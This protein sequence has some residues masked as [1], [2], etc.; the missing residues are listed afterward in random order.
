MRLG[1]GGNDADERLPIFLRLHRLR[2]LVAPEGRRLLRV[3][4]LWNGSV[5]TNSTFGSRRVLLRLTDLHGVRLFFKTSPPGGHTQWPPRANSAYC[6]RT[7][8][9]SAATPWVWTST[10]IRSPTRRPRNSVGGLALNAMVIVGQPTAGIGPCWIVCL[11][12]LVSIAVMTPT[13]CPVL[14]AGALCPCP[15]TGHAFHISAHGLGVG[16]TGGQNGGG[17]QCDA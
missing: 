8:V 15:H 12:A 5:P 7:A 14:S 9:T 1:E 4:L 16:R 13:P 11:F 3:L 10:P 6:G 17:K 2:C